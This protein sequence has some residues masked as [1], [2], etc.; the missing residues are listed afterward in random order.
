MPALFLP[1]VPLVL[2]SFRFRRF[3]AAIAVLIITAAA[4]GTLCQ[5]NGHLRRAR[6]TAVAKGPVPQFYVVILLLIAFP[7]AVAIQQR[8]RVMDELVD[9]EA[10]QRLIADHSDDALLH[11]DGAGTIRF[12]VARLAAVEWAR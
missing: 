12:R 7:M 9:R 5:R 10:M 1:I 3:G 8:Q 4:A 6:D 2:A 11:L